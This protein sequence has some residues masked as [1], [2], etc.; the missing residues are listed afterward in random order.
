MDTGIIFHIDHSILSLSEGEEK[1][2][3]QEQNEL[4]RL[5]I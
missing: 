2:E 1:K 3:Y 5:R 4:A